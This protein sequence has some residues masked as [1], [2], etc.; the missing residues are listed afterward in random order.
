MGVRQ[1]SLEAYWE[2]K[3]SLGSR[4]RVVYEAF[5]MY[6]DMCDKEVKM[7]IG[8]DINRVTP[9][10]KELVDLGWIAHKGY[11]KFDGRKVMVW[12]LAHFELNKF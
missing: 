4:Q 7:W 12:G 1:T 10:R 3:Q 9:R 6:G 2:V 11:K 8:W 5:Q